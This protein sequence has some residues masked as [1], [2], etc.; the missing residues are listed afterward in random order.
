MV[1]GINLYSVTAYISNQRLHSKNR[2]SQKRLKIDLARGRAKPIV[3]YPKNKQITTKC[4]QKAL[5]AVPML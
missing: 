1:T 4:I 5:P 2:G 3:V